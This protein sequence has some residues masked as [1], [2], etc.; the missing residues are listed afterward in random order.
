MYLSYSGHKSYTVCP[1][2]YWHRYVGKTTP[3]KPDNRINSIYGSVVG[4]L[5]EAFYA[6]RLWVK[7]GV[8]AQL[9]S[10]AEETLDKTL[11]REAQGGVIDFKD[12]AAN[13]KSREAL[14][15][16]V[17]EAIPRGLAII[18]YHRLLGTDAEAEVKLDST[19]GGH[20]IG[21]RA[22]FIMTRIK[23]HGD[24]IILDGKGSR[25]RDKYVDP[26]QLKWYAMLWRET[27]STLP[28]ALGFVFWRYEPN[29][30]VDWVPYTES[31]LDE[32]REMVVS[33]A[34]AIET[35]KHRLES[36]PEAHR[37]PVLRE[38]FPAKPSRECKLCS[39]LTLCTEAQAFQKA[40][41][42]ADF[43]ADVGVEDI[44]L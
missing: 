18:R 14:L 10:M 24:R 12:K 43:L 38:T 17:R 23:P 37:L 9:M 7:P 1:R 15:K 19:I 32:Q 11:Q 5:F 6:S 26:W 2:Q 31:D 30:A 41:V 35:A 27:H 16:D 44:G 33:A 13:Y 4:L 40:S 21:G 22:D 3:E 20:R 29:L 8:E 25:H 36:I 28:D 39:Y 42:P 34:T